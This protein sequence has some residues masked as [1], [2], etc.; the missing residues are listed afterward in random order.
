MRPRFRRWLRRRIANAPSSAVT[1]IRRH[2]GRLA[3]LDVG[4]S[5]PRYLHVG[6]TR[7][8]DVILTG[9][10]WIVH[11]RP[12][13]ESRPNPLEEDPAT[14]AVVTIVVGRHW[15]TWYAID[16]LEVAIAVAL[17]VALVRWG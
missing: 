17:A 10:G 12:I 8:L 15:L 6:A 14:R 9:A 16:V 3:L 13:P 4:L 7:Y 11:S 2:D 5:H 1:A